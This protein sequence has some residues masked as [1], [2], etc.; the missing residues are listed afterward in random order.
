M[1][2]ALADSIAA[3]PNLKVKRA[4]RHIDELRRMTD[5]LD[6]SLYEIV[7]SEER[8]PA[9]NMYAAIYYLTYRPKEPIPETLAL[10][11]GDAVHNLRAALDHLAGG[12]LRTWHPKPPDKP[13]FPMHPVRKHLVTDRWLAAIEEALPGAEELILKEIRPED[14][15]DERLWSFNSLDN[16]DK[17]NLIIP[18]V[19]VVRVSN[20]N[21]R[22]GTNIMRDCGMGGDAARPFHLIRSDNTPIIIENNFQT[23]VAVRFGQGTAFENE[24]VV[25]TLT[26]IADIVTK[27]IAV[28]R[29]HI[30]KVHP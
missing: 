30:L 19:S 13:F 20:I 9:P 8:P 5:P 21:T 17:H 15:R 28:F 4:H 11:V 12:I 25:P 16:L 27:T 3:S 24:P 29:A 7:L 18:A 10:I 1:S 6:R 2:V 26:Q 14:G 23:A 22:V